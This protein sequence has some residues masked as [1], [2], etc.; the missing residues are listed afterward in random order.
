MLLVWDPGGV[1]T[2]EV[3]RVGAACSVPEACEEILVDTRP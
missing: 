3:W 1:A 2:A